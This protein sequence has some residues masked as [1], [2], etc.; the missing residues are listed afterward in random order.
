[1]NQKV[2]RIGDLVGIDGFTKEFYFKKPRIE[3]THPAVVLLGD[4]NRLY[5]RTLGAIVIFTPL[6]DR[7]RVD[8]EEWGVIGNSE[9]Y[10]YFYNSDLEKV[11]DIAVT[12]D[13]YHNP[14]L[15]EEIRE[16]LKE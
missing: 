13:E 5:I 1:M 15:L 12:I 9:K 6:G 4:S 16:A 14:K 3:L 7:M 2:L 11:R 8:L 10:V